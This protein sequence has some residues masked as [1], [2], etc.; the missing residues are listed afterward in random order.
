MPGEHLLVK[1]A[2]GL[3]VSFEVLHGQSLGLLIV[4]H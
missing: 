2:D 4:H 1:R 3:L